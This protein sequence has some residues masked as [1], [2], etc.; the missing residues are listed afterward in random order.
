MTL[1]AIGLLTLIVLTAQA[2]P[3]AWGIAVGLWLV[4]AAV[5]DNWRARRRLLAWVRQTVARAVRVDPADLHTRDTEWDGRRLV[6]AEID[7]RGLFRVEDAAVR[8]RVAGAVSW[9]LR[10]AGGYTV[11]WP[12]GVN[13]FEITADPA[14]PE[15]VDEQHWPPGPARH[16]D[17]RHRHRT[18]RRRCGH[19]RRHDR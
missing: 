2:G 15:S 9:A 11:S 1:P 13:T 5:T 8:E 10:H 17:R 14:L 12:V 3:L 4:I 19:L 16:P 7:T 18:R 6:W